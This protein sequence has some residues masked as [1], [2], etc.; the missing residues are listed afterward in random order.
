MQMLMQIF[1]EKY[2]ASCHFGILMQTFLQLET[3][4][5]QR[6]SECRSVYMKPML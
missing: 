1:I 5:E 2:N 3:L 6:R 4:S